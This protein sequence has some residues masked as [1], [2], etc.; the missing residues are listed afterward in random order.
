[1]PDNPFL[2]VITRCY[3]RPTM[4][5]VNQESLAWQTDQDYEQI[6][7]VDVE[8]RGIHWANQSLATVD[9]AGDYVLILDDDDMLSEPTA[10]EVLKEAVRD[11]PEMV[12]FRAEHDWLGVLPS[13]FVWEA[14]RPIK[15][16][17]GSCDFI[18]RRD[19]W[20]RHIEAF[21]APKCGDYEFLKAIWQAGKPDTVWIDD[22]LASVQRIGHGRPEPA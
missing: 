11:D 18:T 22:V 20:E 3:R 13:R 19:V 12:F 15:G 4:L 2:S 7:I 5:A 16:Q 8:G 10:I 21:G 14:Q 1:M 17:V 9:P 6:L